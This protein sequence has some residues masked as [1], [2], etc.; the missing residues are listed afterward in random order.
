MRL[1]IFVL[2]ALLTFGSINAVAV[3]N[4]GDILRKSK[5]ERIIGTWVDTETKGNKY[6]TTYSWKYKD[7]VI[8]SNYYEGLKRSISLIGV[9]AK[10]GEVFNLSV[11]NAGASSLG[12]WKFEKDKATLGLVYTDGN[13]QQGA[14]GM[15][16][17]FEND[18]TMVLT[19]DLPKPIVIKMVRLKKDK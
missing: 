11:D 7:M 15:T 6:K 18:D 9:N 3:D 13:G 8:E 12:K 19:L 16:L 17:K 10:S 1:T 14:L 2:A 4:L 5:W